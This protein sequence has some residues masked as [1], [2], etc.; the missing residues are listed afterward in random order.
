MLKRRNAR[1]GR[2]DEYEQGA[3]S[4]KHRVSP[5]RFQERGLPNLRWYSANRAKRQRSAPPYDDRDTRTPALRGFTM[6]SRKPVTAFSQRSG[7]SRTS[8]AIAEQQDVERREQR[9]TAVRND[10]SRN[11][12]NS[13]LRLDWSKQPPPRVRAS[14]PARDRHEQMPM[15]RPRIS[16]NDETISK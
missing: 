14:R 4:V 5:I 9:R 8:I 7:Q 12:P 1:S 2:A 15:T 10:M 11:R 3:R 13:A 16:A 6:M